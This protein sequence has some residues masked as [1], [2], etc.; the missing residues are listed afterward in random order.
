MTPDGIRTEDW[1]RVHAAAC[2]IVN[3]SSMDDPVLCEHHTVLLFETLDE[4]ERHYGRIPSILATRADF[5]DDP[6]VA[7][8]L[9]EEALLASS[10][11]ISSR[12]AL[13]SLVRL[14][15]DEQFDEASVEARLAD[16]DN[17][18]DADADPSDLEEALGLRSAF[19]G[20]RAE[21]GG[22]GNSA[23]LPASP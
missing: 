13:Q 5:T 18:T 6:Q 20:K 1:D 23:A 12:L 3:A 17:F 8:L 16:L 15:I 11:P 19:E 22:G 4:L 21:Q 9:L 7:I 14:M 10:D 2:E